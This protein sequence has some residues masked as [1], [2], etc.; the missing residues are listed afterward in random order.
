MDR[1][2]IAKDLAVAA[3][4]RMELSLGDAVLGRK[5]ALL[6]HQIYASLS[7]EES[8]AEESGEDG[9]HVS[10]LSREDLLDLFRQASGENGK[11]RY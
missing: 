3:L 4:Q 5:I 6:Y 11:D 8:P 7:Q 2:E 10:R 1:A 9:S